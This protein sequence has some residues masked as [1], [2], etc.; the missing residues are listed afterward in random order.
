MLIWLSLVK[1]VLE[2][3]KIALGDVLESDCYVYDLLCYNS[4]QRDLS[5]AWVLSSI[6][7]GGSD[8]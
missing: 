5:H 7:L 2:G 6:Q 4:T 8:F 3:E 1:I